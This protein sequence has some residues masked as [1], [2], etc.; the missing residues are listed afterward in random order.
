MRRHGMFTRVLRDAPGAAAISRDVAESSSAGESTELDRLNPSTCRTGHQFLLTSVLPSAIT[1][2]SRGASSAAAVDSFAQTKLDVSMPGD[3][4]EQEADSVADRVMWMEGDRPAV[5]RRGETETDA[6]HRAAGAPDGHVP[7]V[8]PQVTQ[9]TKRSGQPLDSWT[10]AYMEPRFG[11]DF[12]AV[13]IHAD[14]EA[15]AAARSVNARAY[16]LGTSVV[17]GA[18]QYS[19]RTNEG[20]RL[21]AHELTHVVQQ[22]DGSPP[23]VQRDGAGATSAS[24]PASVSTSPEGGA[25]VPTAGDVDARKR[26]DA[27]LKSRDPADVKAIKQFVGASDEEKIEL[28][29]ILLN[30]AWVGPFDEYALEDI[31]RS[32]GRSVASVASRDPGSQLWRQ[33]IDAGAELEKLP[34]VVTLRNTFVTDIKTVVSSYLDQNAQLVSSEMQQMGISADPSEAPA[35]ATP[36]QA[37]TMTRIQDAAAVVAKLQ[38]AQEQAR[39]IP[40]G[41]QIVTQGSPMGGEVSSCNYVNFDPERPPSSRTPPGNFLIPCPSGP[42]TPYEDVKTKF[43]QATSKIEYYLQLY[44]SLYAI[45][46]EGKSDTTAAFANTAD[47]AQARQQLGAGLRQLTS[48]ITTTQKKLGTGS[49][50]PLDLIPVQQQLLSGQ[51]APSGTAWNSGFERGL[52]TDMVKDHDFGKATTE[53]GLQAASAALFLLAPFTGGASL[54]VLLA[55]VAVQGGKLAMSADQY[56]TLATAQ[57]SSPTPGTALVTPGQVDDAR[58]SMEADQIALALAVLAVGIAAAAGALGMAAEG[59]ALDK[60]A[61]AEALRILEAARAE[62]PAVSA[63]LEESAGAAGGRLEGTSHMLKEEASLTRKLLDR[64]SSLPEANADPAGA[65]RQVSAKVNDALRYTVSIEPENY[66]AGKEQV[67][68]SLRARGYTFAY[69]WDAWGSPES[70]YRGVNS[71]WKTPNGQL[72]EVQF[73]TPESYVVKSSPEIRALYEEW[74]ETGTSPERKAELLKMMYDK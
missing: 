52:A 30:Q 7:E 26:I 22:F 28:I 53:L 10:R 41:Y 24:A 8:E 64:A 51:P 5:G 34:A 4:L 39:T 27:A 25:S 45:S 46:R 66:V 21:L 62:E 57:K 12:G 61:R 40:V 15:A 73:H 9:V 70:P 19:P 31:W 59:T 20:R 16:T 72:F 14:G 49:L 13:R 33:S 17:F 63:A 50:D 44:P 35:D 38:K 23:A 2:R 43:D 69:E 58:M 32:F 18:G 71:T 56:A 74:R 47:P 42:V 11:F 60:A 1:A 3:P 68:A 6:I 67:Y 48:D 37:A 65:V 55:G 36:Q 54:Y 29:R